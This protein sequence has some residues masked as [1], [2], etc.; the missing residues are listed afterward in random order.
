MAN[1]KTMFSLLAFWL[2]LVYS[3]K[4]GEKND[5]VSGQITWHIWKGELAIFQGD[6]KTTDRAQET[7]HVK[8]YCTATK[9]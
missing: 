9:R 4:L 6:Y 2:E 5:Y 3:N 1:F 7:K 8:G